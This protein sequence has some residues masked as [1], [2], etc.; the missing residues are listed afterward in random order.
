[1]RR[2]TTTGATR[3]M[4]TWSRP[5]GTCSAYGRMMSSCAAPAAHPSRRVKLCR[6]THFVLAQIAGVRLC[7]RDGRPEGRIADCIFRHCEPH[8]PF[9]VYCLF[10][11][12]HPASNATCVPCDCKS[13]ISWRRGCLI[14]IPRNQYISFSKVNGSIAISVLNYLSIQ[15]LPPSPN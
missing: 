9:Q 10:C 2:E 12:G 7:A 3:T 1:M 8:C 14:T 15:L 11:T 6:P 4:I 5:K 13:P